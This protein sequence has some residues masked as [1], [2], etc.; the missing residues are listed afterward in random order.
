MEMRYN[1]E[2]S[3]RSTHTPRQAHPREVTLRFRGHFAH[4]NHVAS[5]ADALDRLFG[6][7]TSF[8]F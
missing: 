2:Y 6:R 4:L 7:L 8:T 5:K 1:I 3:I